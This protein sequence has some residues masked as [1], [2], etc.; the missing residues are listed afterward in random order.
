MNPTEWARYASE[1][2]HWAESLLAKAARIHG[3]HSAAL[4]AE[5]AET[6]DDVSKLI[7]LVTDPGTADLPE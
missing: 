2:I 4:Y 3:P 1:Q 5:S 7:R 6:L